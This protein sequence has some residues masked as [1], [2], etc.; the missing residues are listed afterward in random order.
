MSRLNFPS[1]RLLRTAG[2]TLWVL[3]ST[4]WEMVFWGNVRAGSIS[5]ANTTRSFRVLIRLGLW[6]TVGLLIMLLFSDV[7]RIIS[8]LQPL[9]FYTSALAGSFAPEYFVPVMVGLLALAWAYLLCGALHAHW[10]AKL[11]VLFLFGLFNLSFGFQIIPNLFLEIDIIASGLGFS[12]WSGLALV[13]QL[14]GWLVLLAIFVWRWRRPIALGLEFPLMLMV[15]VA[16]L[17]SGYFSAQLSAGIFQAQAQ[18]SG[19]QLTQAL[20]LISTFLIPFLLIAGVEVATFGMSLT[21]AIA[22]RLRHVPQIQEGRG[23]RLWI[24]GLAALLCIRL[25]LQWI[26]PLFNHGDIAFSWGAVVIA[27]LLLV[28]F[29]RVRRDQTAENLPW[30]MIPVVAFALYAVLFVLQIISYVEIGLGIAAVLLGRD[31]DAILEIFSRLMFF[32]AEWNELF[33]GA[34]GVLAGLGLWLRARL[35]RQPLPPAA[36]YLFI[37]SLWITWW[38]FTRGNRPLGVLSFRYN[39]LSTF[40]TPV[41]LGILLVSV[42]TRRPSARFASGQVLSTRFLVHLTAAAT[43]FW[44]LEFQDFLSNPLSSAFGLLGAQAALLSVSIFL[45]VMAAGNR[46][47]LNVESGNFPRYARS[48]MYFGYALLTVASINWLAASHDVSAMANNEQITRNGYVAIGL[49]L[50]FW[51]LIAGSVTVLGEGAPTLAE[52]GIAN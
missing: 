19:L 49:P 43:L 51:A 2:Q 32:L 27:L 10:A 24:I 12:L 5:L 48:L 22:T 40:M 44:L 8:P 18:S 4:G 15:I 25:I 47:S 42:A 31:P 33:V 7:W 11:F 39:D 1:L 3:V 29:A 52:D 17:F 13:V 46:F 9:I 28:I 35:K 30:W 16:L 14:G 45:N 37:F 50:A 26:V 21:E 20:S 38:V 23:Q 6:L 36:L 41:L 34:L